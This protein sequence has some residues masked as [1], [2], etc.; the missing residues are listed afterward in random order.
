MEEGEGGIGRRA[1]GEEGRRK[2]NRRRGKCR[3]RRRSSSSDLALERQ[4]RDELKGKEL[5]VNLIKMHFM[6]I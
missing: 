4:I 1:E 2:R 6:D 3:K 5:D